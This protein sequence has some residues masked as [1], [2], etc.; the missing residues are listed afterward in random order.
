MFLKS[1]TLRGFKSF[2]EKTTLEFEPGV[3]VV[4]GPNGSGKSNLVDAVAWVLG[5]QG[6][7]SLRGGKMDDVI[8]AGTSTRPSLGRAE[9]SLTIDN[10]SATLPIEFSEVTITRTLFR[11]GDSEYAINGVPCRL[12]DIQELLSDSGIGRQQHVIVGQGQLD[13]VLNARP[14][15]RRLIIEEAAGVLKYRKRREKAERRLEATEGNLL[16]LNDLLREVRRGLAPLQRQADAARR[17]DGLVDEL[18]AIRTY[19]A[20]VE[21]GTLTAKGERV[22]EK[23]ASFA[24]EDAQLQARLRDLDLSVIDAERLL[25]IA[26]HGDL[27]SMLA[28]IEAL[29]ERARGIGALLAEKQR[30]VERELS[31]AAD[32]GVVDNFVAEV[33]ALREQLAAVDEEAAAL[34]QTAASIASAEAEAALR[35]SEFAAQ[36]AA[37][38]DAGAAEAAR[39]ELAARRDAL[40][41]SEQEPERLDARAREIAE[42]LVRL[43]AEQAVLQT[44]TAEAA[45]RTESLVAD[46]TAQRSAFEAA[47]LST[48]TTEE[49]LRKAE[50]EA[51]RWSAR[52]EALA[53]AL[54]SARDAAG[55][56]RIDGLAGV[57]GPLVDHLSI[58]AG[59]EAA[60]ASALGDA[61][62]AIVVKGGDSVRLALDSLVAGDARALLLVVDSSVQSVQGEMVP[63]G[64]RALVDCVRTSLPGLD[65]V[66]ARLLAGHILVDGDWSRALDAA[67]L[68]PDVVAVTRAGDRFGGRSAWRIGADE[69]AGVTQSAL[70]EA[71]EKAEQ[72]KETAAT[73]RTALDGAR[74]AERSAREREEL[75]RE[76]NRSN[77]ISLENG[78]ASLSRIDGEIIE[79]AEEKRVL[80]EG[81]LTQRTA[82][83]DDR[84]RIAEIEA[85]LPELEKA[86]RDAG[87]LLAQRMAQ[88][89]EL[90]AGEAAVAAL[91]RDS[92]VASAAIE[93]RRVGL[94]RRLGAVEERLAKDPEA[95]ALAESRRASLAMRASDFAQVGIRLAERTSL[96]DVA[97]E[98]LRGEHHRRSERASEAGSRLGDLRRER[99]EAERS[100]TV[101]REQVG[102]LEVEDAET[103]M[104]L[105]T[106]VERIR[107]DFDCEPSAT[108]D[109]EA[110]IAPEGSTL[111][112]RGR[113][114]D[115]ELRIMGPINPLALEEYDALQ[116]RHDFLQQQLED[117]KSSRRELQRV[118]KA[119]DQEI[120]SVFEKAFDD[121]QGNFTDLFTTLFPGGS[122]RIFLTD[123]SNLLETGIEIE[124]RPSGKN[125]KRL[126]L[127]SG[128]ERSLTALAFLFAVFRSRP[129]PFYLL[130][131]VEAAL[132]DVNLH[133][134]LDLV[135]EFRDEAQL[136]IVTHQRRTMEAGDCMFGVSMPPG[137]ST[138]VVSQRMRGEIVLQ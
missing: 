108:L 120:I 16:R 87:E 94:E 122:G 17:H 50:A 104:R 29:R 138:K 34:S 6:P 42:R 63:A 46:A 21:L 98:R 82:L 15:D 96:I 48:Q 11:S 65:A 77:A 119:V 24:D 76:A 75:A 60:V 14:E 91:R 110:P 88:R 78:A 41:R 32:E 127:L 115:R 93:E 59:T 52:S 22:V 38:P 31:A 73:A 130:D 36:E 134:F 129:S 83:I 9:V 124:A 12:L 49:A 39:R 58:E 62:R 3:M 56:A 55:A 54:D 89:A 90:E 116:E 45:Q 71:R 44:S 132:D 5:A 4:V 10:G 40:G 125:T 57:V 126:S 102:R 107:A 111:A 43:S 95:K 81:A 18:R 67:L 33:G 114:L 85:A 13:S 28:R 136:L 35:R 68:R 84:A 113:D 66:L 121:V 20:G 109:L 25:T 101:V 103:R 118:I 74:A 1:L 105:E 53:L 131:E 128:G 100:L 64:T 37:V 79:R 7:R 51:S 30:N 70:D 135:R 117:V 61:M 8:F 123:P 137:G 133:R 106:L 47:V 69:S 99:V 92:E 23:R 27:A 97:L 19:L 26:G 86:E 72:A 80:E 112:G 2:A